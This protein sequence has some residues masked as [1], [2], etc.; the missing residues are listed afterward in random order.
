MANLLDTIRQ[1]TQPQQ[2]GMTDETQRLQTLLRAKSGK[3]LG[4]SAVGASNLAE[5]QAVTQTNQQLGQ[6]AGQAEIQNQQLEGQ[7]AQQQQAEQIQTAEI[8]QS[9]KFD[10]IQNKLKT[11]ALLNDFERNKGQIDLNRDRARAEQLG[12]QIRLQDKQYIDN[13]SREGSKARLDDQLE[14]NKQIAKSTFGNSEQILK[15]NLGNREVIDAS[16]REF[17]K[18]LTQM[19]VDD[20]W[21]MF[22]SEQAA[23]RQKAMWTGIGSLATAAVGAAGSTD[24]GSGSG[25]RAAVGAAQSETA[26]SNS[27]L[28]RM[29][30]I[31]G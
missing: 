20:A 17:S 21:S 6:V 24:F 18:S 13:L 4:G 26:S 8:D 27:D 28:A 29:K 3:S 23:N 10:T 25:D 19:G 31:K 9:R 12:A 7:Q 1:N 22:R 15:K 11:E 30:S 2:A 16:D 14:F 5:Q